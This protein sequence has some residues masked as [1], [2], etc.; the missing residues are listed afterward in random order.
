[1]MN[2]LALIGVAALVATGSTAIAQQGQGTPRSGANSPTTTHENPS[3]CL[4]AERASRNSNGGDRE[5]GK[6]GE[7]QSAYVKYLNE[8][9]QMS[10]GE[11]LKA[12]KASCRYPEAKDD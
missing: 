7:E 4:G 11:F 1:M 9:G 5:H 6:F 2:K 10:F 12:Y 3:S 8:G